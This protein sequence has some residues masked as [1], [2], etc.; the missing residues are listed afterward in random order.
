MWTL[1][2]GHHENRTPRH[3]YAATREAAMRAFAKRL[4]KGVIKLLTFA[5]R[6]EGIAHLTCCA[7]DNFPALRA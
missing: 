1:A 4:A 5:S 6:A 2:F 7:G 3:A